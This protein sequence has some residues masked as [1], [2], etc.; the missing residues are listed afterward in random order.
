MNVYL[1][2]YNFTLL[3]LFYLCILFMIFLILSFCLNI[4]SFERTTL[5]TSNNKNYIHHED[6]I[7][8]RQ[9]VNLGEYQHF[10]YLHSLCPITFGK[11]D[12]Q[13]ESSMTIQIL[14]STSDSQFSLNLLPRD[15]KSKFLQQKSKIHNMEKSKKYLI[16]HVLMFE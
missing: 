9:R 11:Q 7:T 16:L 10:T 8:Q 2:L 6:N 13:I 1:F 4:F 12:L 14:G 5:A 15:G 3:N